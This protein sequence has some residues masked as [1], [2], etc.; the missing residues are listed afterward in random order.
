MTN[1]D[2]LTGEES[3]RIAE[4]CTWEWSWSISRPRCQELHSLSLE[5]AELSVVA[6]ATASKRRSQARPR[7]GKVGDG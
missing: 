3:V 6:R 5:E 4:R 7:G 2:G 1:T